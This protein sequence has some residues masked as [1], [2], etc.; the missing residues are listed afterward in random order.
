LRAELEQYIQLND[1]LPR[2]VVMGLAPFAL[3]TLLGRE[4]IERMFSGISPWTPGRHYPWFWWQVLSTTGLEDQWPADEFNHDE[5]MTMRKFQRRLVSRSTPEQQTLLL[6]RIYREKIVPSGSHRPHMILWSKGGRWARS[7]GLSR[8]LVLKEHI[9]RDMDCWWGDRIGNRMH[10]L[11]KEIMHIADPD[12]HIAPEAYFKACHYAKS[13]C[14]DMGGKR[15]SWKWLT[16]LFDMDI[17][18]EDGTWFRKDDK[19]YIKAS[20]YWTPVAW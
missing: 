1:D 17:E 12:K 18:L 10:L 19:K 7:K 13:R 4:G 2:D 8:I 6:K 5:T 3:R 9:E 15:M 20:P 11:E 16:W 14:R